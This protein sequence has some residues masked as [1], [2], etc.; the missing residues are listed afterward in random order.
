MPEPDASEDNGD[1]ITK[2][3]RV[4]EE[5]RFSSQNRKEQ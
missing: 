4:I 5:S 2:A 1:K 3:T